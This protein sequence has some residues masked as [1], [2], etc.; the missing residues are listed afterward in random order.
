MSPLKLCPETY[1]RRPIEVEAIQV[2]ADNADEIHIW[3]GWD[4]PL[5]QIGHWIVKDRGAVMVH[6]PALFEA[7]HVRE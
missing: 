2:T 6:P 5:P 3:L 7:E 4:H 1:R